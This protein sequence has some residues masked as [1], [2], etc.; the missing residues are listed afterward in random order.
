MDGVPSQLLVGK[1]IPPKRAEVYAALV[2]AAILPAIPPQKN[3]TAL[4]YLR[5]SA[6]T[7]GHRYS[8]TPLYVSILPAERP[9]RRPS[10]PLTRDCLALTISSGHPAVVQAPKFHRALE[11]RDKRITAAV[12]E[13]IR[14]AAEATIDVFTPA[15]ALDA[16][17]WTRYGDAR[18]WWTE[19][20]PER[21]IDETK[22]KTEPTMAQLRKFIRS[23]N[24]TSPGMC[25]R[26]IGVHHRTL[27]DPRRLLT[28]AQVRERAAALPR[29][30]RAKIHTIMDTCDEME[31]L[32][33]KIRPMT[34][35]EREI[36]QDLG[37]VPMP[38][39]VIETSTDGT[40]VELFDELW[41][42]TLQGQGFAPHYACIITPEH[43]SLEH[44]KAVLNAF[45]GAAYQID[46]LTCTLSEENE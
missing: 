43:Q 46:V 15:N 27:T 18:T 14:I 7:L 25:D 22:T 10:Q 24:I 38:A 1:A 41:R 23:N 28:R 30:L 29:A 36:L 5:R 33:R 6:A 37:E 19:T 16:G 8:N 17:H 9:G 13:H 35:A 42:L 4:A 44:V 20:M 31:H 32:A 45:E 12:F 2:D 34:R 11:N 39:I 21:F 26:E 3:E 40:V